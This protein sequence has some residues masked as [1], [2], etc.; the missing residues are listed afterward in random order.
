MTIYHT[1]FLDDIRIKE[2]IRNTRRECVITFLVRMH[3]I[4]RTDK[5]DENA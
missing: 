2:K 5:I 3:K 1:L 4:L